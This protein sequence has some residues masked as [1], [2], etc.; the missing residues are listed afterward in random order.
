MKRVIWYMKGLLLCLCAVFV[1]KCDLVQ[2]NQIYEAEEFK[3]G[4][5][6]TNNNPDKEN[7]Y[8]YYKLCIPQKKTIKV[9]CIGYSDGY[10]E[11]YRLYMYNSDF[12][13]I[14]CEDPYG[15]TIETGAR[16]KT[17]QYTLSPGTYYIAV[18]GD[19]P[20]Y[21]LSIS[22]VNTKTLWNYY[23]SSFSNAKQLSMGDKFSGFLRGGYYDKGGQYYKVK[24]NEKTLLS[25]KF[26]YTWPY[27]DITVTFFNSS[28]NQIGQYEVNSQASS[29]MIEK[30]LKKGTY[31]IT[32]YYGYNTNDGVDY[33]FSINKKCVAPKLKSYKKGIRKLSGT[34]TPNAKVTVKVNR[35]SYTVKAN[36]RG[37]F[38][39][40]LRSK[41]K[42]R[43]KIILT[44]SKS[45]YLK[46]SKKAYKV[47]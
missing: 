23:G 47:K 24:L 6:V 1:M 26:I 33:G 37:S 5:T 40:S 34:T 22:Y 21:Q 4:S 38:K 44:A 15:L 16:K 12:E 30:T 11:M 45:K 27:G 46:S 25:L 28:Y 19:I 2:A 20:K 36:N 3:I 13:E 29:K 43:D 39:V 8:N 18:Q 41:L 35:K 7:Y 9:T 31:Y 14:D 17:K 32:T 42:K 10:M